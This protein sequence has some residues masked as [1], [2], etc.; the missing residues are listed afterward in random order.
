MHRVGLIVAA[1]VLASSTVACGGGSDDDK[2][3]S[4]PYGAQTCSDWAG[5]MSDTEHWDAAEELLTNAKG[6][7]GTEGDRAPSTSTIKQFEADL[8]ATCDMGSSDELLANVA[9]DVYTANRAFY[10]I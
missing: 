2:E 8:S 10:G 1:V 9:D 4:V 6:T 7:D 3:S 5:R